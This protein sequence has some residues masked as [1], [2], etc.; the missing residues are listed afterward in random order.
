MYHGDYG[1][2]VFWFWYTSSFPD[3]K[4][5]I[6]YL[7]I[8]FA[9]FRLF[10]YVCFWWLFHADYFCASN[11]VRQN[12]ITALLCQLN[13]PASSSCCLLFLSVQ[14][15]LTSISVEI[16]ELEV[17]WYLFFSNLSL[18]RHETHFQI[19]SYLLRGAHG[20]WVE[21]GNLVFPGTC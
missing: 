19:I 10:T 12:S 8:F 7:D 15:Y 16:F 20:Y 6:T 1:Q 11:A 13:L 17:L 3:T 5:P 18:L 9:Y 14:F 4:V 21:L 2:N